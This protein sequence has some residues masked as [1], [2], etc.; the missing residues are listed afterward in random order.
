MSYRSSVLQ[1]TVAMALWVPLAGCVLF[2]PPGKV[3]LSN[4]EL[5]EA[6]ADESNF[7]VDSDQFRLVG[8]EVIREK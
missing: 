3:F 8:A 1:G 2:N 4:E 5:L 6:I 7:Q